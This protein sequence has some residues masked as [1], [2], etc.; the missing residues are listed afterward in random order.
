MKKR[1]NRIIKAMAALCCAMAVMLSAC[2]DAPVKPP[3]NNG[4][5]NQPGSNPISWTAGQVGGAENS[6]ATAGIK[7]TF[8]EAVDNLTAQEVAIGGAAALKAGGTPVKDA[9]AKA[10]TV[11][12]TVSAA[13]D[14]TVAVVKAGVEAGTKTVRVFAAP[15]APGPVNPG[16][17]EFANADGFPEGY[18]GTPFSTAA[19]PSNMAAPFPNQPDGQ[20]IPGIVMCAYYDN[21]PVGVAFQDSGGNTGNT[22]RTGN[23]C[24]DVKLTNNGDDGAGP[25][26]VA[27]VMGRAYVGWTNAGEWFRLTV[28]VEE[29][30]LYDVKLAYAK[31]GQN[32]NLS[33]WFDEDDKYPINPTRTEWYHRWNTEAVIEAM[34]LKAGTSV[35]TVKLETGGFN[36][37]YLEF[38]PAEE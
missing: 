18:A 27:P 16:H 15:E 1:H 21:G 17:K 22:L 12:V 35:L 11:P 34:P 24:V 2:V 32:D 23:P 30:G 10:W 29:T 33:I 6:A 5:N 36:L 7:I 19:Y 8:S 25:H 26:L 9:D 13:G 4:G 31:N 3:D 20:K 38:V 37:C 14:A 28:V